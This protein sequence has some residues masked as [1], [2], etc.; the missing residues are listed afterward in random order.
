MSTS[1]PGAGDGRAKGV[2]VSVSGGPVRGAG[3]VRGVEM[4]LLDLSVLHRLEDELGDPG[5]ARTFANEYINIWDKRI[6][7]LRRSVEQN[8][9]DAAMDA[10]LSVRNSSFMVG[11]SRLAQLAAEFQRII[12]DGDVASAQARAEDIAEVGQATME[13]IL[14]GYLAREE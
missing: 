9:P 13:A 2:R 3:E 5:I 10:V 1:R 6:Q 14:Q 11:A 12:Q 4:P 7:H 8:D